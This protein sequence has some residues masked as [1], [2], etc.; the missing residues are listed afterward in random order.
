[1]NWLEPVRTL[2]AEASERILAIYATAFG[3]T[4][5]EDNSPLTAADLAAHHTIAAIQSVGKKCLNS[6]G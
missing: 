4:A 1:L 2:A 6:I 3:V 5:K